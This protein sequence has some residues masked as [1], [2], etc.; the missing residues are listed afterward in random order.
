MKFTLLHFV[1]YANSFLY[2]R[3]IKSFFE[4]WCKI[5]YQVSFPVECGNDGKDMV[6]F[7]QL[8]DRLSEVQI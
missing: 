6:I 7:Q 3:P 2:L 1:K 8:K 5:K 4:K